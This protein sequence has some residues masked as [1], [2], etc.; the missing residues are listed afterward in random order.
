MKEINDV[1]LSKYMIEEL[2]DAEYNPN[3]MQYKSKVT[4]EGFEKWTKPN[5]KYD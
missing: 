5:A 3:F 4:N 2:Y 1:V